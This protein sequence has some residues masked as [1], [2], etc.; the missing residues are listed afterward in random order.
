MVFNSFREHLRFREISRDIPQFSKDFERFREFFYSLQ[1][2]SRDFESPLDEKK[3]LISRPPFLPSTPYPRANTGSAKNVAEH[4]SSS[5]I[6]FLVNNNDTFAVEFG[7]TPEATEVKPTTE[8]SELA[9][10]KRAGS[11]VDQLLEDKVQLVL[12]RV[13]EGLP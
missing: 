3:H 1:G 9:L 11:G 5:V 2:I 12:I 13:I 4:C 10:A 7:V 8:I 6:G